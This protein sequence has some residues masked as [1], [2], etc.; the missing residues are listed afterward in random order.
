[1]SSP[2]EVLIG[3]VLKSMSE[4]NGRPQF[5]YDRWGEFGIS[6]MEPLWLLRYLP[7]M[8]GCHIGIALDARGPNNS[9]TQDEASGGRQYASS[10]VG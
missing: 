4:K 7:N 10:S 3:A 8:P 6:G 5:D 1:M 9:I 2:P